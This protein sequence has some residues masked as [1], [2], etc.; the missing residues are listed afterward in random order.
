MSGK[1]S[2]TKK[3][4]GIL[5]DVTKCIGCER[6]VEACVRQNKLGADFPAR[7]KKGDG[8]SGSRFCSVVVAPG[9]ESTVRKQCMHCLE[10]SCMSACLVGAFE[11]TADGAVVYDASKCIGCRYCML[12]CP[13]GIPRYEYNELLPYVKKCKMNRDCRVDGGAPACVSACPTGATV[14]GRREDLIEEARRRLKKD[15]ARYQQHIW[16]EKE[17]GGTCVMYIAGV[18]VGPVL[19]FPKQ[20]ELDKRAVGM[21]GDHSIPH[22]NEPWVWVTPVQFGAVFTGLWGIWLFRRRTMLMGG[23]HDRGE[24]AAPSPDAA[25][26]DEVCAVDPGDR[27]HGKEGE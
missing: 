24:G 6:C 1:H 25:G 10:P 20:A 12:A 15:P 27:A 14:F 13:F 19:G 5:T 17:F 3:M 4:K 8:L 7:F 26:I 18:D 21:L 23:P 16:G 11:K 22:M 2:D 9:S